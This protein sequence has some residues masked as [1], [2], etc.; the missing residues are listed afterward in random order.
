MLRL[1][2]TTSGVALALGIGLAMPAAAQQSAPEPVA[3][4]ETNRLPV[5]LD[6]IKRRLAATREAQAGQIRALRLDV[7][8]DVYA[9]APAIEVLG[10][11]ELE[12]E[13][14]PFGAPT[15]MEM[16]HAVTPREWRPRAISTGNL[17][18][19]R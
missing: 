7:H 8:V 6:R 12:S 10:D 15:H 3:A 14:V 9:R 4:A 17:L 1:R 5:S 13:S 18:S 16:L 2:L 11:L 19:W